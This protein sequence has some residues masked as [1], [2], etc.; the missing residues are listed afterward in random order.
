MKKILYIALGV[1]LSVGTMA[2][3]NDTVTTNLPAVEE[4]Q[5]SSF[6]LIND[7]GSKVKIKHKGGSVS[8]NNGSSTSL[9]CKREGNVIYAN[10]KKV[11]VVSADDC[12]E[13][14]KLSEWM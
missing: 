4:C 13:T 8:L 10:G 1:S 5:G 6:K 9:S 14:Y 7:T 11:H 2:F 3:T 12:G